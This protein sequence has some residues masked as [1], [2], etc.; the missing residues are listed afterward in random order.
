MATASLMS[1][2]EVALGD[3]A[4]QHEAD[5]RSPSRSAGPLTAAQGSVAPDHLGTSASTIPA[6]AHSIYTVCLI[7]PLSPLSSS[8]DGARQPIAK[9]RPSLA[10][11]VVAQW[12]PLGPESLPHVVVV[13]RDLGQRFGIGIGL[14]PVP[15]SLLRPSVIE[16]FVVVGLSSASFSRRSDVRTNL[17][18]VARK[19]V[20]ELFEPPPGGH[21]RAAGQDYA[22]S[23]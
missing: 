4:G 16:R 19:V 11:S 12:R 6:I 17:R 23:P 3:S 18:H 8:S 2:G 7:S 5:L 20:P 13:L 21:L 1:T 15:V 22:V 9:R 14:E 10:R